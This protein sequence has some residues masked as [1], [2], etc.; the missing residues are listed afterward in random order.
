MQLGKQVRLSVALRETVTRCM[1]R[2]LTCWH[3]PF[4]MALLQR[5]GGLERALHQLVAYN[6]RCT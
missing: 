4:T 2:T 5:R 1:M 6:L 3:A